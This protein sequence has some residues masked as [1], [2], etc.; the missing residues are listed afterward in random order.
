MSTNER[1]FIIKEKGHYLGANV[2]KKDRGRDFTPSTL[3]GVKPGLHR[4]Q[5]RVKKLP[6]CLGSS[7]LCQSKLLTRDRVGCQGD[8]PPSSRTKALKNQPIHSC[9]MSSADNSDV[10]VLWACVQRDRAAPVERSFIL[11]PALC[12]SLLCN[13]L[14]LAPQVISNIYSLTI[15]ESTA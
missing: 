10:A 12:F 9:D 14:D 3:V 11:R 8:T 5:Q 15:I 6:S 13:A 7:F 2:S 1:V 4:D